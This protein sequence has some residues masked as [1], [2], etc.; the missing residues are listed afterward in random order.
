MYEKLLR[1]GV[2]F[3]FKSYSKCLKYVNEDDD[4]KVAENAVKKKYFYVP[5]SLWMTAEQIFLIFKSVEIEMEICASLFMCTEV[6]FCKINKYFTLCDKLD[7]RYDTYF[8]ILSLLGL[9]CDNC[10]GMSLILPVYGTLRHNTCYL[11]DSV[12]VRRLDI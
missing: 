4:H 1:Y 7:W 8:K 10:G 12:I 6:N 11:L 9:I 2:D 3:F 5:D